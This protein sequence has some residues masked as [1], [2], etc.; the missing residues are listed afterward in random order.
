M[1]CYK[2]IKAFLTQQGLKFQELARNGDSRQIRIACRQCIGCRLDTAREWTLR[3]QH[4]SK[5][6]KANAFVTL[7]YDDYNL[8]RNGS[9]DHEHFQTFIRSLRKRTGIAIRYYMCGEYA[10]ITMRPHYHA[11]LFGIDF[12]D[13]KAYKQNAMGQ[14]VHTSDLLDAAWKKGFT[15]TAPLT[16][17]TANYTARYILKKQGG[18]QGKKHYE[19]IDDEGTVHNREPDYCRMSLKPG[20]GYQWLAKYVNDVYP[21]DSI[22]QPGGTEQPV[23]T[24]YDKLYKRWGY[25][26]D[27]IK[28]N[29][30][31]R[32][33]DYKQDNTYARLE[34]REVIKTAQ[35]KTL[36]R[37][38]NL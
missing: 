37:K 28:S 31:E 1:P 6:H 30:E 19:Y 24:Y 13:A 22:I 27:L 12:P 32:S 3:I 20:I 35:I 34:V 7:T 15:T 18:D 2:P 29:R 9:L 33:A 17:Q 11:C 5:L 21:H 10:P 38:A 4:E 26:L 8:P 16:P 23:P 36:A 14:W 25:D